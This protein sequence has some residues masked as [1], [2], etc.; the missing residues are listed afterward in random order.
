M[1]VHEVSALDLLVV[2][3][4]LD[5]VGDNSTRQPRNDQA[6]GQRINRA[7]EVRRGTSSSFVN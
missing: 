6:L 7:L 4:V 3:A 5:A 1:S 2:A